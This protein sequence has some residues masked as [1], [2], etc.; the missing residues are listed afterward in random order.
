MIKAN[1]FGIHKTIIRDKPEG[2]R[3]TTLEERIEVEATHEEAFKINLETDRKHHYASF[4]V[5]VEKQD[6]CKK[7][8]G[9]DNRQTGEQICLSANQKTSSPPQQAL[10]TVN[11]SMNSDEE[12]SSLFLIYIHFNHLFYNASSYF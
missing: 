7:T 5:S 10:Q 4:A 6:I 12:T 9:I 1:I 3:T 2:I 11:V 8:V